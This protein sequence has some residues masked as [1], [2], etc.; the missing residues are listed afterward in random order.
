MEQ[1][2]VIIHVSN[3]DV[4]LLELSKKFSSWPKLIRVTAY[5]KRFLAN[6]IDKFS[7]SKPETLAKTR[8]L[9]VEEINQFQDFWIKWMQA[10]F[11]SA[12]I[13]NLKDKGLVSL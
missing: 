1:K 2:T 3:H 10:E 9:C 6:F 7:K 5:C 8:A 4:F 13:K 12:K 11:F